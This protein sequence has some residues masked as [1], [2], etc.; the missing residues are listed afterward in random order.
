MPTGPNPRPP[1]LT[2]LHSDTK[3]TR[4]NLLADVFFVISLVYL[5]YLRHFTSQNTLFSVFFNC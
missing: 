3:K 1:T 5:T 2:P 4:G